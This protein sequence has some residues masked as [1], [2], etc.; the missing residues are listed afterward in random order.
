MRKSVVALLF[1]LFFLILG[2]SPARAANPVIAE[3]YEAPLFYRFR[4]NTGLGL[5]V[6]E[7]SSLMLSHQ[8]GF[9]L[10]RDT[11]IFFGPE[12][13]FSL[14]SPGSLLGI[15]ASGWYETKVYGTPRLSISIGVTGGPS[16]ANRVALLPTTTYA[17]FLD[18]GVLE[19]LD[20]L[21]SVR[22][23][24]RPGY[25]GGRFAFMMGLSVSFRFL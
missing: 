11:P 8:F 13:N 21:A 22:I 16:F 4:L 20:D 24:F 23:Q 19:E 25:E 18:L 12:L 17:A 10:F 2:S 14:F 6:L 7:K 5:H 9:A 3:I 15:W 1:L